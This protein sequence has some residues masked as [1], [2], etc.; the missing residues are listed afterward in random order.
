MQQRAYLLRGYLSAVS[1]VGLPLFA[2]AVAMVDPADLRRHLVPV[3]VAAALLIAGELRPIPVAR[4]TDAGDELSISSTIAVAL[5]LLMAPGVACATQAVALVVDEARS[6][7]AW[8]RLLFNISQYSLSL[9]A[10]RGVFA[11][12]GGGHLFTQPAPFVPSQLPAAMTASMAFFVLN[13][14]L[15][16][17]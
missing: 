11:L 1:L 15:T 12:L 5:L 7:R 13:N 14:G 4:G 9:V 8:D 16:G 10:T 17:I 3:V 2:V 6:R